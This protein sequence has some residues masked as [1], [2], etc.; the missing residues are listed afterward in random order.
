MPNVGPW[1]LIL[2]VV[3]LLLVF[4]SRRLPEIGRSVGKGMREFKQSV[5]GKD[6]EP[7]LEDAQDPPELTARAVEEEDE[8]PVGAGTKQSDS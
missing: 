6:E 2:L 4:G 8:Q 5:T 3:V 7:E 1:E